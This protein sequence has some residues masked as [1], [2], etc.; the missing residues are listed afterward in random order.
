MVPVVSVERS[1]LV[2][3]YFRYSWRSPG[4]TVPVHIW[5][6]MPFD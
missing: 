3:D 2:S 5:E 6:T 1:E 4:R